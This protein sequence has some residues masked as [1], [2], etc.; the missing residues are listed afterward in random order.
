MT[1]YFSVIPTKVGTQTKYSKILSNCH[2][3][4]WIPPFA[5]MTK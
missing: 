5:G 2:G 4:N 1:V 3:D